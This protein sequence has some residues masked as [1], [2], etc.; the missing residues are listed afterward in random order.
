MLLWLA[1]AVA[2]ALKAVAVAALVILRKLSWKLSRKTG[3]TVQFYLSDDGDGRGGRTSRL[4]EFRRAP[5][6]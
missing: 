4:K 5:R 2:A 3:R 1:L 6:M